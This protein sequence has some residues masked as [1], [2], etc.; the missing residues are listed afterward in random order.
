LWT[1]DHKQGRGPSRAQ[2]R[3]KPRGGKR[4]SRIV[5]VQQ[6]AQLSKRSAALRQWQRALTAGTPEGWPHGLSHGPSRRADL[7]HVPGIVAKVEVERIAR[8]GDAYVD[9]RRRLLHRLT[10]EHRKGFG[11]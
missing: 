7:D 9:V 10:L 3:D 8:F 5:D 4:K 6:C 11:K 2:C 1:F